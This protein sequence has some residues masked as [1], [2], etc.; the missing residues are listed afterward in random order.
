ML[1]P[2]TIAGS[3]PKPEWLA[4]PNTL[5]APW[6]SKGDEL[7]RAKAY[8]TGQLVMDR[9]TNARP[10]GFEIGERSLRLEQMF[11]VGSELR[12]GDKLSFTV[13]AVWNR[14]N[15]DAADIYQDSSLKEKLN[16]DTNVLLGQVGYRLTPLAED[17]LV[18]RPEWVKT[19]TEKP[20]PFERVILS[21]DP[22]VSVKPGADQSAVVV[23]KSPA[24]PKK[25]RAEI[26]V[27]PNATARHITLLLDGREVASKQI[28]GA[29]PFTIESAAP[30]TGSTLEIRVD[31]VPRRRAGSFEPARLFC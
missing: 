19:W 12:A 18:I 8:V 16:R 4:E 7:A 30:L 26:Y 28:P 15:Y 9:R 25:L 24:A 17:E 3:L 10:T 31:L 23:L 21:V 29:G 1:F 20:E 27:P 14:I 2:T 5:W 13:G 6:K 11:D 22:A